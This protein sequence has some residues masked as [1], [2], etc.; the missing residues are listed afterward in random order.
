M[1]QELSEAQR[2]AV[3]NTLFAGRKIE[4][5]KL[6]REA[7]GL[8]LKEAKDLAEAMESELRQQSPEKFSAP[9]AKG[10]LGMMVLAVGAGLALYQ[11]L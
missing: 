8:G 3:Q 2:Q 10:C 5:I 11:Y 9:A 6:L 4:A 7:T 1:S